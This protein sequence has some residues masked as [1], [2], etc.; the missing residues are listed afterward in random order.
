MDIDALL[1]DE[2]R[3]TRGSWFAYR[4]GARVRVAAAANP[5]FQ[6][7]FAALMRPHRRS[8]E[9]G[10]LDESVEQELLCRAMARHVL[11]DWEGFSRAGAALP[12]S[13]ETACELL[14]R[15]RLFRDEIAALAQD[16]AAFRAGE[17]A[18]AEKN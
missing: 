11:L 15:S 6:A 5:D 4:D 7:H 17:E 3:M 1:R 2:E 16:E 14:K 12:Y 13:E 18:R 10:L 8:R 9:L